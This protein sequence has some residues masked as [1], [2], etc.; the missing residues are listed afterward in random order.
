M[1]QYLFVSA[2]HVAKIGGA[3]TGG[4]G[5][6]RLPLQHCS[7]C[8]ELLRSELYKADG[9]EV[10]HE[11]ERGGRQTSQSRG[12]GSEVYEGS[13][14]K[15]HLSPVLRGTIAEGLSVLLSLIHI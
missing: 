5:A 7:T 6:A 15:F 2:L 11:G 10:P 9:A 8:D 4:V 13:N 14:H 12:P 1:E 3:T